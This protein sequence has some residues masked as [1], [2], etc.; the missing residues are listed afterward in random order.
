MS[1]PATLLRLGLLAILVGTLSHQGC[2]RQSP[3]AQ[4]SPP[5]LTPE[6]VEQQEAK[7]K[8]AAE[9]ADRRAAAESAI[10]TLLSPFGGLVSV[11]FE[12]FQ[13]TEEGNHKRR[14]VV[15]SEFAAE[16]E[17]ADDLFACVDTP[18]WLDPS[19]PQGV[20][21][22]NVIRPVAPKGTRILVY[23]T[24]DGREVAG[25][26]TFEARQTE[27]HPA[28]GAVLAPRDDLSGFDPNIVLAQSRLRS[29]FG[30][31][32]VQ[33]SPEHLKLVADLQRREQERLDQD[34]RRRVDENQRKLAEVESTLARLA[35]GRTPIVLSE[36]AG[37]PGPWVFTQSISD[38]ALD[39]ASGAGSAT[40][41]DW[42]TFPPT[43]T[44]LTVRR[45]TNSDH[46]AYETTGLAFEPQGP[47]DI[48]LL[49]R[50]EGDR[51]AG[52]RLRSLA[53]NGDF[54]GDAVAFFPAP[55][56]TAQEMGRWRTAASNSPQ[57]QFTSARILDKQGVLDAT[58]SSP[59]FD[60][61]FV[62][63][64][65][66][67]PDGTRLELFP[68]SQASIGYQIY[69]SQTLFLRSVPGVSAKSLLIL[70]SDGDLSHPVL[71]INGQKIAGLTSSVSEG[72]IFVEFAETVTLR[73][74]RIGSIDGQGRT[75]VVTI[76]IGPAQPP[77]PQP[78]K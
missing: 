55:A 12:P 22:V 46:S 28:Q 13:V 65:L 30:E 16:V 68:D 72:G 7:A 75:A 2:E 77:T 26:H 70:V 29:S 39:P 76:R 10:K 14:T 41:T 49:T 18:S 71:N 11:S 59:F 54:S 66:F 44:P 64:R 37:T 36:G 33:N 19:S 42:R 34:Q 67:P 38:V 9:E 8:A 5:D 32:V 62:A 21:V 48:L 57:I 27:I 1:L 45:I 4:Q 31:S 60:G 20:R 17:A 56:E 40:L 35:P 78:G 25:K 51:I 15:H 47:G 50:L 73:E 23:G 61:D 24:V 63:A 43:Q 6:Q 3:P 58:S 74:V 52:R 53:A 69:N